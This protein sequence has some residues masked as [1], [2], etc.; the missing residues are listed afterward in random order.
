MRANVDFL[1]PRG[2]VQCA[3]AGPV[4][5]VRLDLGKRPAHRA[6]SWIRA[7]LNDP[8][9][10]RA[11]NLLAEEVDRRV[12]PQDAPSVEIRIVDAKRRAV[13]IAGAWQLGN[14]WLSVLQPRDHP[15][16]LD[17]PALKHPAGVDLTLPLVGRAIFQDGRDAH[18]PAADDERIKLQ[19]A[20]PLR[21]GA[22]G[23]K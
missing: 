12:A 15:D 1:A 23:V 6:A 9:A 13:P 8:I 7:L 11:S 2:S 20:R 3:L 21:A 22:V 10:L 4:K 19:L 5:G 17:R 18:V 16:V 14:A